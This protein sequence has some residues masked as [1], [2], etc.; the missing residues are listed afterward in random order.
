MHRISLWEMV[1]LSAIF[2]IGFRVNEIKS[3]KVNFIFKRRY[4]TN[5]IIRMG[6]VGIQ[7]KSELQNFQK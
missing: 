3:Q 2:F 1:V 4:S 7:Q 5:G 6:A